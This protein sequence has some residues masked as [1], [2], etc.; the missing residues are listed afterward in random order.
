MSKYKLCFWFR[1]TKLTKISFIV[2][3]GPIKFE[4]TSMSKLDL[5]QKLRLY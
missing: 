3:R 1:R 5:N 2:P 4:G